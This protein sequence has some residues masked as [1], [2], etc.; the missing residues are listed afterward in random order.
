MGRVK[1][2]S[3]GWDSNFLTELL[4][5]PRKLGEKTRRRRGEGVSNVDFFFFFSMKRKAKFRWNVDRDFSRGWSLIEA[6]NI[7]AERVESADR[8]AEE[9]ALNLRRLPPRFSYSNS[10]FVEDLIYVY[11]YIL[12]FIDSIELDPFKS[13]SNFFS[14]I[15]FVSAKKKV[16]LSDSKI[17]QKLCT[18]FEQEGVIF[19]KKF[20]NLT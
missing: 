15:N 19:R 5:D 1:D 12:R 7:K 10:I 18:R 3:K 9:I 2:L 4:S 6:L 14:F 20:L 13:R 16:A 17:A 11:I 8:F